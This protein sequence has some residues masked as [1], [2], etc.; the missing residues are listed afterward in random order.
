M[1]KEIEKGI[2]NVIN[3]LVTDELTAE[4]VGSGTLKVFAT[5][6]MISTMEKASMELVNEFLDEDETTVG[7]LVNVSHLQATKVNETVKTTAEVIEVSGR[8]ITFKVK[9][10]C[11]DVLI[12]EGIHER[13]IVNKTK[14][15]N[16]LLG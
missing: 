15:M 14:F 12:G 11:N 16:K 10:Y 3:T 9:S 5:P 8:K 6:A 2:S 13:F 4:T 7:T 1:K